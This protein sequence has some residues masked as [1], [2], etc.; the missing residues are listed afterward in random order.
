VRGN[1]R[2]KPRFTRHQRGRD[3]LEKTGFYTKRGKRVKEMERPEKK[4]K[5]KKDVAPALF[6]TTKLERADCRKGP[7][8]IES[9]KGKEK[10]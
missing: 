8:S 5:E 6:W 7:S 10:E 4:E 1:N 2:E 3:P 9:R